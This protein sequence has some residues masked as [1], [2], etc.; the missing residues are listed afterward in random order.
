MQ[1]PIILG[2]RAIQAISGAV[3]ELLP[4]L[5]R[6]KYRIREDGA[7]EFQEPEPAEALLNLQRYVEGALPGEILEQ[8]GSRSGLGW[9]KFFGQVVSFWLPQRRYLGFLR[10]LTDRAAL[11]QI[12][13][14]LHWN[15]GRQ[16]PVQYRKPGQDALLWGGG[17]GLVGA[18]LVTRI[19]RGEPIAALLAL[20]AGLV[21]GRIYQRAARLRICGDSL[22]RAP[23]GRANSCPS[24]GADLRKPG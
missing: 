19:W 4:W 8:I 15:L 22:C 16:V 18:F 2:P 10:A 24:C 11:H 3:D 5:A 20:A 6:S 1:D 17:A 7:L 9:P 14:K 12:Q 13:L 21:A 23:A